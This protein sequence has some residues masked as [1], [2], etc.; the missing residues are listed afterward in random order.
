MLAYKY[1]IT[2]QVTSNRQ[3]T[4][5]IPNEAYER[6]DEDKKENEDESIDATQI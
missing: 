3:I 1:D 5:R 2:C 4:V 6:L